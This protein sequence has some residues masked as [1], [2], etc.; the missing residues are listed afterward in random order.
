VSFVG[1]AVVAALG[2]AVVATVEEDPLGGLR[3]ARPIA[4][5]STSTAATP[6]AAAIQRGTRR[7]EA[8]GV[9]AAALR[10]RAMA[11]HIASRGGSGGTL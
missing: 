5:P 11:S 4:M 3:D 6:A 9:T 2:W 8:I 1:A 10:A 7:T